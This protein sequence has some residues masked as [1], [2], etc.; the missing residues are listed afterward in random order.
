MMPYRLLFSFLMFAAAS[1]SA[2]ADC[3]DARLAVQVLGSGGPIAD[4]ARASA[5]YLVWI[6]GRSRVL[7]DAGGGVF[8]RLGESGARFE[9]LNLIALTHFHT[10][11]A[12]ELP[13]LLKSAYF[14]D[15]RADLPILG[16]SGN[17]RF[18]D[19]NAFLDAL[20]SPER[21][22]FRYLSGFLDGSGTDFRLSPAVVD[23]ASREAVVMHDA[24][25]LVVSAM[26]VTHGP[27]P[28]LAYRVAYGGR[29]I[30]FAG[31]QNGDDRE[32]PGFAADADLL[33]MPY[34]IPEGAGRIAR[35]LHALPSEI[36]AIATSSGAKRLVLSHLM[37]RSERVLEESL[38]I[39]GREYQGPLEVAHDMDCFDVIGG[40]ATAGP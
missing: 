40:A 23:A 5:A 3:S 10:D 2:L 9:D 16:P 13:A 25:G 8:V 29:V 11:H 24:D 18:P 34:A 31:D 35:N 21:G 7:V 19:L 1:A 15:R 17:D 33:I 26:G 20:F 37:A 28:A 39:I 14:S 6:D 38:E 27:V 30:V 12:T 22:A 32:F 4:D 36:G